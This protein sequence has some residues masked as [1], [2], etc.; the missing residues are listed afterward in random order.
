MKYICKP[1]KVSIYINSK[2]KTMAQVRAETGCDVI[3]NGGLFNM[4][5]FKATGNLKANGTEIV[6]EW[7]AAQGYEWSGNE[8]PRFGWSDM[9]SADN[10][11]GCIALIEDGTPLAKLS[12]PAEMGGKRPRTAMGTFADGRIWLYASQTAST[13]EALQAVAAA[14]GVKDAVMLDGGGSTQGM[15]PDDTVTASRIVQHFVCVWAEKTQEENKVAKYKVCLDAGHGGTENAN[16]SPDGSYKEHRAMLDIAKRLKSYLEKMD[17]A[18]VMTRDEDESVSLVSRAS[19]ANSAK[20]DIYISLHSNAVGG[21]SA[22]AEG[23]G[24][25]EGLC[26]FTYGKGET[27]ARNVL[28]S[29]ILAVMEAEGVT[30]HGNGLFHASYTVLARTNMPAVLIEHGFH[31]NR[32]EVE[33]LK[34][35][36]Y[37]DK[38]ALCTAKAVCDYFGID[39]KLLGTESEKSGAEE[40][41]KSLG[42]ISGNADLER[43][44]TGRE[45]IETLYKLH[46]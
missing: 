3:V 39:R 6:R 36:S 38:L 33:L 2:R 9:K 17:I 29:K 20:A 40:W 13:P 1:K 22:D 44:V 26:I 5:A 34:T 21:A 35:E 46:N 27:L 43:T 12:Y 4:A 18:V 19:I 42:L 11:I 45:F 23:W 10:Y 8:L 28:A 25:A 37:R 32:E 14:A 16:G 30:I 24:G 15:S 31:T 41:A 7:N